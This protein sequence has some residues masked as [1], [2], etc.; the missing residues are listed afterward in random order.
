M[1]GQS[2]IPRTVKE[3]LISLGLILL[4]A[5]GVGETDRFGVTELY[6]TV[7]GG[8]EWTSAW[9]NGIARTFNGVD[10]RDPWFDADHGNATYSTDG[11][12]ILKISGSVPRMYVHDPQL[13][14]SWR[15][16]EM[17]VYAM[18]VADSG[19][20]WGGIVGVARSNH[21]TTGPELSNLCDTRG[22][23]A[24][25]RY[26]GKIDFE[27]ETKHPSSKVVSSKT[28]WS[29]GMPKNV[30][31][32]YKYVVQDLPDGNVKM[33]LWIDE[34]DG[35]DGGNWV[36]IN[37]F[38][39]N[40]SNFGV[41]G[42]PCK[43]G[44]DPALK[45]TGSDS[46]P[47]SE[48]G[49]PNITVYWRSDNVGTN[50]LLY[51]KMSVR[52]ISA[53][54]AADSTPPSMS[55]VTV[56]AITSNGADVLWT[57]NEAS[58]SQV[59][60]GPTTAYGNS[61]T[62][63][64]SLVTGHK[65]TLSG[66]L[67]ST[68]YHYRVKSKDAA[69]NLAVSG[70][71]TFT[72]AVPPDPT[73]VTSAAA[74]QN[75]SFAS[76]T[77]SF[78]AEFE[79]TPANAKMDGVVG[80]SNGPAS[81]YGGLAAIVRFNT[82]GN[83]DARNGGAY[84][85]TTSI[86]YSAGTPYRF[87][88]VIN[89]S[90]RTYSVYVRSGSSAEQLLAN[91][92]SFRTEQAGVTALNNM[93]LY[94]SAGSESACRLTVTPLDTSPPILSA[95]STGSVTHNSA[96]VLWSSNEA[97]DSQVEYGPTTGYGNSTTLD[98]SMVTSHKQTLS[99]LLPSALYHYRVKSR[100]AAGN[101]AV[102]G[103]YTFTTAAPP[104]DIVFSDNFDRV[105][106]LV[107]NEYAYWNPT[108][109]GIVV[110]PDWDVTSGSLIVSDRRG[111]T[112]I[113]DN[114]HPDKLSSNGTNSA[115][116]RMISKKSDFA[117]VQLDFQ[118]LNQGFV[119]TLGTPAVAWD[120]AHVLLRYLGED[121]LYAA[122]IN[123]RDNTVIIKKK[124]PGGS[125]NGGTYYN[126]TE[127]LRYA[128][129][130]N[131]WQNVRAVIKTNADGSVTLQLFA[132][133]QLVA[134]ATDKGVGGPPITRPGRLGFRG[135][136]ANLKFDNIVV[137]SLN[138]ATAILAPSASAPDAPLSPFVSG[139]DEPDGVITNEYAHW[140]PA[141]PG[142]NHDALWKVTSGSLY[143][144]G[145]K[146]WTGVPDDAPAAADSSNG[147]G[148]SV[149]RM[150]THRRDFSD[151]EVKFKLLN[152]G[153]TTSARTPAQA[154]DGAHIFLRYIDETWLYYASINRRDNKVIIKK[155]VPGG[156]SNG[157]TYYNLSDPKPYTVPY[158][159]WQEVRVTVK[160]NDDGSVTI[161][162]FADGK[163][164]VGATDTGVGGP[165]ITQ[166]GRV[167]LRGDN[168]N[169]MFEDYTVHPLDLPPPAAISEVIAKD[170]APTGAA[171]EWNTDQEA[172][173]QVEYGRTASYGRTATV[174][175]MVRDHR[176]LLAGLAPGTLYHFRV[177]S[178]DA[179]GN[180]IVS[181]DNTFTT[182]PPVP[183]NLPFADSFDQPNGLITNENSDPDA[184]APTGS[185]AANWDVTSG[186]L[187]AQGGRG[188]TGIPDDADPGANSS[189]GTHSSVFRM[190]TKRADFADVD[191]TFKLH[192][193]GL[194]STAS[195]PEASGDG[196][197]LLLRYQSD[198]S[199][200]A[201][202][203]N[204]RD[205]TVVVQKKV[206][207]AGKTSVYHNLTSPARYAVPYG[208]RQKI[209]A[210]AK[211]DPSGSVTIQLFINDRPLVSATDDGVGGPPLT[212]PTPN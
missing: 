82:T 207:G 63:D 203:L 108:A 94:A 131:V 164:L 46:R 201:V 42:E 148:S 5:I 58:D 11:K 146:G 17:T 113:P 140:N 190:A 158:N 45:L 22:L 160:T 96:I 68:L 151:V 156:P 71:Y 9:D 60:Y 202:T 109:S 153:L 93:G 15:S 51:K 66:L 65:Q 143:A 138:D 13:S 206:P 187:F 61:T 14:K 157:G 110:S 197:R 154:W 124:V 64:A 205:D 33:E 6:P 171:I 53:P 210:T 174:P 116:F 95:V 76:Q 144:S 81:T 184:P 87:R 103:D 141:G 88:L 166:S 34:T 101:L 204:R 2:L 16:V 19:T 107:T 39:D 183:S 125:S 178:K 188:W 75:Q 111:W 136:N 57:T 79:A 120:G 92:F 55:G 212:Q 149:F 182:S 195:T 179:A 194:V 70:D 198:Q 74:W 78:T 168:A 23:G 28:R 3:L 1:K 150:T 80:L 89:L 69:G 119:S 30:W 72:T 40:G 162:L 117:D 129:P 115:V 185:S 122:S 176:V 169:L 49:K 85:A 31:I 29:G 167:G 98:A 191:V 41:G 18:R 132:N 54:Q 48:S 106:G 104:S 36:K 43:A 121:S 105:D 189:A 90:A 59:E 127:S 20:A 159:A 27:K 139:F 208:V 192:N 67:P 62:L 175:A 199:H 193:Q 97:S 24:R 4:P 130:F 161:R 209:R 163:L 118:L 165:P 73:C 86:P 12:G 114:V 128:V 84:S 52:E 177:Q 83:I 123:R 155:K 21:G 170:I 135:D 8:M 56:S 200:Y 99:G 196:A 32:G 133:G 211:N 142:A 44:I 180:V 100:D 186:S 181:E 126:L 102:S 37:E 173:S 10:P 145:G 147:S 91:N 35:R 77:G 25:M 134:G 112:G 7:A 137:T 47:G 50:G 172:D 26:D 152:Q 38:I